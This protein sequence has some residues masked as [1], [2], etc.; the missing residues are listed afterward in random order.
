[1]DQVE[2]SPYLYAS[3]DTAKQAASVI[4]SGTYSAR[5][6]WLYGLRPSEAT[7][8]GTPTFLVS[9]SAQLRLHER[10][11]I[12]AQ[13]MTVTRLGRF[14]PDGSF[15]PVKNTQTRSIPQTA[16]SR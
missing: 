13:N 4:L 15:F 5:S 11:W 14:R 3:E 10:R 9:Y 2:K 1:M 12:K 8:P 6:A 16:P 7:P